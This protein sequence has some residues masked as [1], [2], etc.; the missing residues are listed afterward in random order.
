M[1][2]FLMFFLAIQALIADNP[3]PAYEGRS[4]FANYDHHI[5]FIA[6]FLPENPIII[7]AGA[8]YGFDTIKFAQ[9]WPLSSIFSFE[10]NPHAFELL[11]QKAKEILQIHAFPLALSTYNGTAPFYV[12]YGSDGQEPIYEGASSLLE[13]SAYMKVHYQGPKIEVPCVILDDWC[14]E[15]RI[16]RIDFMWLDLEGM[17]LQVL[18]SSPEILKT[19]KVI[20]AETNFAHLRVGMTHVFALRRFLEKA[21][22]TMLAHWYFPALQGNALFVRKD[23]I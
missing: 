19:V 2:K 6:A 18:K 12:C 14:R 16:D 9:K 11:S 15:N 17:E 13:A 1:K 21:G 4:E 10:P 5:D 22:F 7:E 20:F 3:Y 23:L 8:H